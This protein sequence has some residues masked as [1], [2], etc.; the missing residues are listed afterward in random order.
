MLCSSSG[1]PGISGLSTISGLSGMCRSGC[2]SWSGGPSGACS[3]SPA[4]QGKGQ[5]HESKTA[6]DL[7]ISSSWRQASRN[8]SSVTTPSPFRSSFCNSY[9]VALVL[10]LCSH[11]RPTA[12]TTSNSFDSCAAGMPPVLLAEAAGVWTPKKSVIAMLQGNPHY[13]PE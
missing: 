2:W 12:R 7:F 4:T 1:A 11:G 9:K 10:E 5:K 13:L 3:R 6:M 8:S